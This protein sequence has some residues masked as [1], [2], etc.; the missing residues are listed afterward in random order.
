MEQETNMKNN[1]VSIVLPTYNEKDN[2]CFLVTEIHEKLL[3]YNHEILVVDDNS[4]DGTFK[5][6]QELNY[7]FIRPI[8]RTYDKGFAN[9]IRCGIENSKGDTI[10]I[11]DSD[12]NHQPKYLVFMIES[13]KFYDCILASRF[14]YGGDMG[15][16]ARHLM[17]W[18]FNI[19][20]R[21]MTGGKVTD[22]LYGFIAIKRDTMKE[23]IYD[24]VFWGYGDYCIRL[25]YYLQKNGVSILQYPAVNGKRFAG[26]GNS[27]FLKVFK[28][29]FMAVLK[30]AYKI[31]LQRNV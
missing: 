13:L 22:S 11:M 21:L 18:I 9:S 28:Q 15:N 20:V 2:I 24:N 16:R 29:Y 1:L 6:L 14:V 26:E 27:R 25:V 10:I 19:F 12:F 23:I 3:E 4:P 7:P 30:L 31:K 5:I 17:S 8:L